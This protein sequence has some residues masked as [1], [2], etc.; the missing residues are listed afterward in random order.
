MQPFSPAPAHL[1]R[2]LPLA[3]PRR[4]L[5]PLAGAAAPCTAVGRPSPRASRRIEA[6]P[7]CLPSPLINLAPHRLLSLLHSSKWSILNIHHR[8]SVASSDPSPHRPD[9]IKGAWSHC[10]FTRSVLPHLAP[11]IRCRV[12]FPSDTDLIPPTSRWLPPLERFPIAL[13]LFFPAHGEVFPTGVAARPNSGEPT[14]HHRPWST[15]CS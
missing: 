15:V 11:L 5:A 12:P 10:H 8:R 2:L 3:K 7:D 9:A 6:P 4:R 14:G 1:S 13:S